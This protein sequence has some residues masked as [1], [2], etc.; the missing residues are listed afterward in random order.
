MVSKFELQRLSGFLEG[1]ANFDTDAQSAQRLSGAGAGPRKSAR[2]KAPVVK[3][4]EPETITKESA[5]RKRKASTSTRRKSSAAA[6]KSRSRVE[7]T[8]PVLDE[9]VVCSVST[10]SDLPSD[11]NLDDDEVP[12]PPPA[13]RQNRNTLAVEKSGNSRQASSVLEF[14]FDDAENRRKFNDF[15]KAHGAQVNYGN[16]S[17]SE[18]DDGIESRT[19]TEIDDIDDESDYVSTSVK[20]LS[21]PARKI[22]AKRTVATKKTQAPKA[23][24]PQSSRVQKGPNPR[25][26]FRKPGIVTPPATPGGIFAIQPLPS[27]EDGTATEGATPPSSP[28]IFADH[29]QMDIDS[30]Q[31][32]ASPSSQQSAVQQQP[33][34][35]RQQLQLRAGLDPITGR[36]Y[37]RKTNALMQM[38]KRKPKP[39]GKPPV[40]ADS[41]QVL[42]ETVPYYRSHHGAG[43]AKQG[44]AYSFMFDAQASDR[45]YMDSTVIVSRAGGGMEKDEETGEMLQSKDSAKT[46]IVRA[47]KNGVKFQQPICVITGSKNP[48]AQFEVPRKY[49]VLD[50]FKPTHVWAEKAGDRRVIR[51]RFEVLDSSKPAWWKGEGVVEPVELGEL[52]P[53]FSHECSSCQE[54][55]QQ[56]YLNGWMC[57]NYDCPALCTFIDGTDP[58]DSTLV[59][60][61]RW[62]K[63]KTP[64]AHA[65]PPQATK[66]DP[67]ILADGSKQFDHGM[68]WQ[69]TKG[70][71]CPNCDRCGAREHW[72]YWECRNCHTRYETPRSI[73]TP[74]LLRD[75]LNPVD[76]GYAHTKDEFHESIKLS[77]MFM[78]NYRVHIYTIPGIDGFVAHMLANKT[79]NE[80]PDGPDDMFLELQKKDIG[81]KRASMKSGTGE[82]GLTNQ[83]T[84]NFGMPYKFIAAPQSSS[85]DEAPKAIQNSRARLNWSA[86]TLLARQGQT[87]DNEFNEVLALAYMQGNKINYHDD[88][89]FGLGP[90]IATLSLGNPATMTLRMKQKHYKGCT[91]KRFVDRPP[92]PGCLKYKER[93]AAYNALQALDKKSPAYRQRL[94]DL[95][96]ELGLNDKTRVDPNTGKSTRIKGE[97]EPM[98]SLK[99]C[100]GGVVIMHGAAIQEYYEHAVVPEGKMRFALTSRYID[101]DSLKDDEKPSWT[102]E[103][104]KEPYNGFK[105]PAPQQ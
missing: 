56:I 8:S 6:S 93:L 11:F 45:D 76:I 46:H 73:V 36:D 60:D 14:K 61:P 62:L 87:F 26:P 97:Q 67:W 102:V 94:S 48:T 2:I 43:Y 96:S 41:R 10:L 21:K 20:R 84:K 104:E 70:I 92:L 68:V 39:Q 28:Q 69:A 98:I 23:T 12:V 89:E 4:S 7:D 33:T 81:L 78:G 105:L 88:G 35:S 30:R 83:F 15:V 58:D 25:T 5:P 100:H 19:D 18:V 3:A 1:G 65:S 64:W 9:N 50:W 53:P 99:L 91:D 55:S 17:V 44:I 74:D 79:V 82:E 47:F 52:P 72:A 95:P 77:V 34:I 57:N 38:T 37:E 27:Y 22:P 40:W 29:A 63:Q 80:E 66:P 71:A 24:V 85:L 75:W 49:C 32:P 42:C 86:R 16:D 90:T 31:G 54:E 59:Y 13:K 103:N 51:Y 101:I